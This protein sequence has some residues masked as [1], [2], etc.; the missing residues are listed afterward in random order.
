MSSRSSDVSNPDLSRSLSAR[1]ASAL[2]PAQPR[3]RSASFFFFSSRR[4][5]TR[6]VSDWSSDVCS[7]DLPQRPRSGN[8]VTAVTLTYSLLRLHRP[9]R[10]DLHHQPTTGDRACLLTHRFV[11]FATVYPRRTQRA[12]AILFAL[13]GQLAPWGRATAAQLPDSQHILRS[14]RAAQAD[15]ESI[16]R[17]NLPKEPGHG[18]ADCDVQIGRFCYWYD[19][20][21]EPQRPPPL[22]SEAITRAR[23]RLL[24]TLDTAALAL[25]GDEWLAGQRV[26]YLLQSGRSVD[27]LLAARAC[28]APIRSEEHTSELQSL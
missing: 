7:S 11:N 9:R 26:R 2:R 22:E 3:S 15:F 28:R 10:H 19:D 6:L 21:A 25:P 14:A 8:E 18:G 4:R 1:E 16:R 13:A 24:A 5:H 27:A 20:A 17:H 12:A 23:D